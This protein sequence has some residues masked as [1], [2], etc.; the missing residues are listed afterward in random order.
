LDQKSNISGANPFYYFPDP[1]K[2]QSWPVRLKF[3]AIVPDEFPRTFIAC[4]C[5]ISH[6]LC[7][8]PRMAAEYSMFCTIAWNSFAVGV[9]VVNESKPSSVSPMI[10]TEVKDLG[11]LKWR[12]TVFLASA[13][14]IATANGWSRAAPKDYRSSEK[15]AW[16]VSGGLIALVR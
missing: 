5:F 16:P 3:Q 7:Y 6:S 15:R 11:T 14:G 13:R 12:V 2:S 4:L 1:E 8:I 9:T 10:R